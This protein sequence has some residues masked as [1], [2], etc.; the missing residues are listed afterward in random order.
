[1]FA[2]IFSIK[3]IIYIISSDLTIIFL[4]STVLAQ[5]EVVHFAELI[6]FFKSY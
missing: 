6:L 2:G 5:D 3:Y 1:M 4:H